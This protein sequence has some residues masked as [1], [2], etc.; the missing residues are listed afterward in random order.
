MK[1][2][3]VEDEPKM[4]RALKLGLEE[5]R[6]EVDC[7][8]DG[9]QGRQLARTGNYEVII[10]DVV[11]PGLSG[12]EMLR[13]L[14]EEGIKTPVLLLTALG[15]TDDKVTGF[16]LGADDYLTKPFEFRELLVRIRAL[17]RRASENAA[18]QG[19]LL[20]FSDLEMNLSTKEVFREK[21][22]IQLTP[23]EFDLLEYFLRNFQNGNKRTRLES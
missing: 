14:R 1:V 11:M 21:Q 15:Q 16:E 10:S 8:H 20:R 17:A 9:E 5:E 13:R 4:V 7:A 3:L 22:R 23:R 19:P 18:P 6:I 2:L 12:L